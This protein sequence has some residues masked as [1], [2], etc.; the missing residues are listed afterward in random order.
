MERTGRVTHVPNVAECRP[1][2]VIATATVRIKAVTVVP[3]SQVCR[4]ETATAR[5]GEAM[6]PARVVPAAERG[7]PRGV[8]GLASTSF[9]LRDGLGRSSNGAAKISTSRK[10]AATSVAA[11]VGT[12]GFH[13][14]TGESASRATPFA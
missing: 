4:K 7:K 9:S 2:H 5:R 12:I 13:D 8:T 11:T 14:Q 1:P 3:P 10:A 6:R